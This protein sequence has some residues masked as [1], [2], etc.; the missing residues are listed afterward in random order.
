MNTVRII[1]A[2]LMVLCLVMI[3]HLTPAHA[4]AAPT[5]CA[6]LKPLLDRLASAYHEFVVMTGEGTGGHVIVTMSQA[7]TFSV[8]L[9]DGTKAC[10]VIAG[11]K[12]EFDKGT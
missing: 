11:E 2:A 9:T 4:Q 1:L 3:W 5:P 12:A 7:G 8:V 6:P 10:L